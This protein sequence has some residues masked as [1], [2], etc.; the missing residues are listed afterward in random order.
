MGNCSREPNPSPQ[1]KPPSPNSQGVHSPSLDGQPNRRVSF[2]KPR[3]ICS[4][5]EGENP[6]VEPSVS[7]LVAC[8]EYQS[9][10]IGTPMWWKELEAVLG[11]TDWPKFTRKIQS[12]FYIPEV[13]SRMFPE[14]GYSVPPTHQSLNRG[15]YLLD[16]LIYQDVRWQP[17]LLTVAYCR[18]LQ[19]WAEK[20]NPPRNPDFH[21]LAESV[22]ELRQA[23]DGRA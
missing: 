18:C 1:P 4:A 3:D 9:T 21:P 19:S 12:S 22:R 17:T 7:N 14:E 10:Q 5:A 6:S 13:W 15:A 11:I 2:C 23:K 16:N 8:L 20:C